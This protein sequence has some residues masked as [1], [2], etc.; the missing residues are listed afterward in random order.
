VLVVALQ[1]YQIFVVNKNLRRED[2]YL[3]LDE[4]ILNSNA[5]MHRSTI[6]KYYSMARK[7]YADYYNRFP[8]DNL[9]RPRQQEGGG[10]S[11]EDHHDGAG[12][13]VGDSM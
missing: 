8:E 13:P 2:V 10:T 1:V 3:H 5:E 6:S 7:M 12:M 11:E 4:R 9:L